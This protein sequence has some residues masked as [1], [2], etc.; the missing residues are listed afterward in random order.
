MIFASLTTKQLA[1]LP[2]VSSA[3]SGAEMMI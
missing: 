3:S 1:A 2:L